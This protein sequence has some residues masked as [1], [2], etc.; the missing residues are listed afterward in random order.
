MNQSN[1]SSNISSNKPISMQPTLNAD[2][3]QKKK[4]FAIILIVIAII[5]L[6]LLSRQ[7]TNAFMKTSYIY[8]IIIS[9]LLV[10]ILVYFIA[11]FD[12]NERNMSITFLFVVFAIIIS[13]TII[14]SISNSASPSTSQI[15]L[16]GLLLIIIL[17]AMAI[18]YIYFLNKSGSRNT[19][20][21]FIINFIFYIPC[22]LS[23]ALNYILRDFI[24]TPKSV[25]N[26]ILIEIVLVITYIFLYP[27]IKQST[28]NN[29]KVL[30][31]TPTQLNKQ[32]NIDSEFYKSF[33]NR[34]EDP[35][36]NQVSLTSPF[37]TTFSISMWI[38]LNIQSFSQLSYT[39]EI[40]IFQYK[41]PDNNNCGCMNHP[42][43]TYKNDEN[44]FDKYILYLGPNNKKTDSIKYMVSLPHQ[45]WNN[46]VFNYRD[47]AVDIFING[48][49]ETTITIPVPIEYT[50]ND[51]ITVGSNNL[52]SD[53]SGAYGSICNI[54]YYKNILSKGEIV[55]NYNLLSI[56]NP[57]L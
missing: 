4:I 33:L 28:R 21:T 30:L 13:I 22:L 38:Y 40:D 5:F 12:T 26:I 36:T 51:T 41:S 7:D 14:A 35:V 24:S 25:Q 27:K 43:I 53:R 45:K 34:K 18:F 50:V 10:S 8:I 56:N 1:I 11:N 54:V 17:L 57:P 42:K 9:F 20:T 23:D 6:I 32:T 29:G 3:G 49:F 39:K 31:E 16:N 55:N 37:R 44:G 2:S 48:N 15:F 52:I 46:I 47:G 19:W